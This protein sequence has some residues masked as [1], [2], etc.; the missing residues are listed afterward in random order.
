MGSLSQKVRNCRMATYTHW[1]HHSGH[2]II[3]LLIYLLSLSFFVII[4]SLVACINL[5]FAIIFVNQRTNL[6]FIHQIEDKEFL[7]ADI[8]ILTTSEL[9]GLCYIET[10]SLDGETN[11]KQRNA[12]KELYQYIGSDY[13]VISY[14]SKLSVKSLVNCDG[15]FSK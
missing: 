10:K 13:K 14:I 6:F 4:L 9:K 2:Y 11:L 8:L 3:L 5:K 12:Q 15:K 1:R 7:P